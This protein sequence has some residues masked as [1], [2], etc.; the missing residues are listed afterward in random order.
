MTSKDTVVCSIGHSTHSIETFV[1]LLREAQIAAIADVR[2]SPYSRWQPQFNREALRTSLADNGITYVF[3]G[4]ELGGRGTDGSVRD[5]HGRVQ[6]RR[7][8][9]SLAF[10]E[11]LR[12][13]RAGSKRM[14]IALM[15]A[16]SDP[17]ECH[18]GIL[19][20]RLLVTQGVS[21]VHIH[22]DGHLETHRDAEQRLLL[23]AGLHAPDL[24]RTREQVLAD[25]YDRQEA[26]VAY[27]MPSVPSEDMADR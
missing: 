16:E 4:T 13:V 22:A 15:C 9:E 5:E 7:I 14:R 25:A 18:R 17:L 20:S 27:V 24:F 1:A 26:R 23:L 10:N 11:G 2:S 3:L 8:A 6:Y 12:R 21:V 19:I